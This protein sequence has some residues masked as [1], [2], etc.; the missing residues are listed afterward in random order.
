[1]PF[2]QLKGGPRTTRVRGLAAWNPQQKTRLLLASVQ[3]VLEEYWEHLPLTVRQV[4]Y[5]LVGAHGY[6][7]S[8]KAYNRLGEHINRARRAGII[9]FSSIRDDGTTFILPDCYHDTD[10]FLSDCIHRSE[11]FTLDR[12]AGQPVRL[13]FCIEAAGM[14]PQ[15]KRFALPAGIGVH[16]SGGFDSLTAKHELAQWLGYW[17]D[18]EVLHI[19]D[20]DP[21]GVHLFSSAAEDVRALARDMELDADIEFT[22]LAVTPEQITQLRLETAPPKATDRRA[23]AGETTQCEAIPPDVLARIVKDAIISRRDVR[24]YEAVLAEEAAARQR[25]EDVLGSLLSGME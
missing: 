9:P 8:E 19:G 6:P 3:A 22:R 25:L 17:P 18:V 1:M 14:V 21:S 10:D 16:S 15:I 24:A 2:D 23:F 11:T 5:R 20:H 13:L 7:K 12:Q 4:F